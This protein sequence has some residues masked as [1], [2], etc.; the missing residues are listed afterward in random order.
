MDLFRGLGVRAAPLNL[1]LLKFSMGEIRSF[2]HADSI[3]IQAQS[4]MVKKTEWDSTFNI[5]STVLITPPKEYVRPKL[6]QATTMARQTVLSVCLRT[7]FS[8]KSRQERQL[9]SEKRFSDLLFLDIPL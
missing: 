3:S 5:Q 8:S 9:P 2:T 4:L 1:A 6:I 7:Y